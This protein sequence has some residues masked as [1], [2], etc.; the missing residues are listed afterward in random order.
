MNSEVPMAQTATASRYK[1]RGIE[2]LRGEEKHERGHLV[3]TAGPPART[4][5]P[6]ERGTA[7]GWELRDPGG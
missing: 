6:A 4:R 3:T 2:W 7:R 1:G 5:A